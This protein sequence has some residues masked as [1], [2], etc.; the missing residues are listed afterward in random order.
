[1]INSSA[2]K[3]PRFVHSLILLRV[4]FLSLLSVFKE[5]W[6]LG[7]VDTLHIFI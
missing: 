7:A 1:M 6:E 5:L 2:Y 3:P 4:A